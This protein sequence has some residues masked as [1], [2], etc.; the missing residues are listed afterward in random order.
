MVEVGMCQPRV[1]E[2]HRCKVMLEA[3]DIAA[4]LF[5]LA[6]FT[7]AVGEELTM[8]CIFAGIHS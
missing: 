2:S 4:D 5:L 1:W 6:C 7:A 3:G 8:R